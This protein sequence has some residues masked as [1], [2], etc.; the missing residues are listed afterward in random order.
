MV[1]QK[2]IAH[3]LPSC[4]KTQDQSI[5]VTVYDDKCDGGDFNNSNKQT[6][7]PNSNG[8]D[9]E[10]SAVK[11]DSQGQMDSRKK[12]CYERVEHICGDR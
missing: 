4:S 11:L 7:N 5:R 1:I 9:I 3:L 6:L 10:S 2:E 12:I 8:M